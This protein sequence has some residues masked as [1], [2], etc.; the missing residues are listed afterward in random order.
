MPKQQKMTGKVLQKAILE[1]MKLRRWTACH[2][3]S[4]LATGRDGKPRW[5]TPFEA[6]GKGWPDI[7]AVRAHRAIA[8]EVKGHGDSL[9]PEQEQWLD[10]L[11][12]AG[13]ETHVWTPSSL[14]SGVVENVLR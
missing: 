7:F 12:Q 10:A 3:A 1:E 14:R 11:R 6:D 13:I 8:I 2:F 9:K 5:R 4:V